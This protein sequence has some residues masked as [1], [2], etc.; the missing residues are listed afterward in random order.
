[1]FRQKR[2]NPLEDMCNMDDKVTWLSDLSWGYRA[3]RV[4]HVANEIDLFTD[5]PIMPDQT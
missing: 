1:M 2:Q 3:A 4:L 5:M